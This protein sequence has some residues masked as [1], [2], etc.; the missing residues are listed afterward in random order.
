MN[1][2]NVRLEC[3]LDYQKVMQRS[4]V[5]TLLW[6]VLAVVQ[7]PWLQIVH[8]LIIAYLIMQFNYNTLHIYGMN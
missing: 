6:C 4:T 3:S 1:N 7:I 2:A 8:A 5:A